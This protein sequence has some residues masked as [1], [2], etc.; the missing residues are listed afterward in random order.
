MVDLTNEEDSMSD[1]DA[2]KDEDVA[3][4]EGSPGNLPDE[5]IEGK[6]DGTGE[7]GK[8]GEGEAGPASGTTEGDDAVGIV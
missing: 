3:T 7:G 6:G 5:G 2:L 4:G 1:E 8:T